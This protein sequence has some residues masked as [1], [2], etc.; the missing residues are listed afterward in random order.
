MLLK[1]VF[2]FYVLCVDILFLDRRRNKSVVVK[3]KDIDLI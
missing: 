1:I 3:D 2:I